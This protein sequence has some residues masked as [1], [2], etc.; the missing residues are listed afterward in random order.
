MVEYNVKYSSSHLWVRVENDTVVIGITEYLLESIDE[1]VSITL[2]KVGEE[3]DMDEPFGSIDT[4]EELIELMA[5]IS[6]EVIK[7][8]GNVKKDPGILIEDPFG[9]GWLLKVEPFDWEE[10][11]N[12]MTISEYERELE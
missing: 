7:V 8:N 9:D 3:I 2:P 12:L 10:V 4:G 5:P 6:G 11:E 1:I